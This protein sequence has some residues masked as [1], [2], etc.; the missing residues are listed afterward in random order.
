MC[1]L[2][3]H[4]IYLWYLPGTACLYSGPSPV[5]LACLRNHLLHACRPWYCGCYPQDSAVGRNRT[6]YSFSGIRAVVYGFSTTAICASNWLLRSKL[7]GLRRITLVFIFSSIKNGKMSAVSTTAWMVA[8]QLCKLRGTSG[9]FVGRAYSILRSI[10]FI[11]WCWW[12]KPTI[13]LLILTATNFTEGRSRVFYILSSWRIQ[14][15]DSP[16]CCQG[17]QDDFP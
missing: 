16:G 5:D 4:E 6:H 14:V 10:S 15:G 2:W 12:T 3:Q 11:I 7:V 13:W 17:Q 8:T 1:F 9:K